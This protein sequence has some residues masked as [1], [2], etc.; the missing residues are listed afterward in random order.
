MAIAGRGPC[1]IKKTTTMI[2]GLKLHLFKLQFNV[3][4]KQI[5]DSVKNVSKKIV[6]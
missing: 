1:F 5:L 6:I 2:F 4:H 3:S